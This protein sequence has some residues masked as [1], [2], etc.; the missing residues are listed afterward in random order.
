[1]VSVRGAQFRFGRSNDA[2]VAAELQRLLQSERMTQE[3][4]LVRLNIELGRYLRTAVE[5][6]PYYAR[7]FAEGDFSAV[8]EAEDPLGELSTL[9]LLEKDAV[10]GKEAQFHST[11]VVGQ[12]IVN[13]YTSGTTGSPMHTRETVVSLSR[14]FA[15]VARLRFWAGVPNPLRPRRVQFTGRQICQDTAPYW[16]YNVAD[17]ALL[18]STTNITEES[19]PLYAQ[20]IA[21]FRPDLMDG[22]PSAMVA[23]ARL[24][25]VLGIELPRVPVIITTA[26]TLTGAMRAEIEGAFGGQVYNQYAASE[27]VA[28]G[29]IVSTAAC[30]SIRN[31][32]ARKSLI[33]RAPPLGREMWERSSSP[34]SSIRLC[35][36]LGPEQGIWPA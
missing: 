10:R 28:C 31:A 15:F 21:T 1:M 33:P 29:L 17:N 19:V 14:R 25:R 3:Q 9:P 22:Y 8:W 7:R 35:R 6:T 24:G 12:R 36:S 4:R 13:G 2:V 20:A 16:R 18:M 32:A 11:S 34:R 23:I 30:M 5:A 26:E 27:P